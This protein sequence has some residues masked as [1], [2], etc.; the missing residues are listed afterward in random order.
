M[1]RTMV[2]LFSILLVIL[3]S[4]N[5]AAVEECETCSFSS[6]LVG[7]VDLQDDSYTTMQI[8]NPTAQV[9]F[10]IV[11]FFKHDGTPTGCRRAELQP[12]AMYKML[13]RADT[14]ETKPLTPEGGNVKIVSL[15]RRSEKP[16]DG[17]VG[18]QRHYFKSGRWFVSE[19]ISESNLATVPKKVLLDSDAAELRK[20]LRSCQP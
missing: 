12:N 4:F 20:I 14:P 10:L 1:K 17:I 6:Y 8:I 7:T 2:G 13:I 11:G 18:F 15:D 19:K 3:L 16:I 9:L 5:A